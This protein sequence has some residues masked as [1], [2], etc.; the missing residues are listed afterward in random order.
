MTNDVAFLFMCFYAICKVFK[1]F[2]HFKNGLFL[3]TYMISLYTW[4]GI[5]YQLS[6]F[7][8]FGQSV[9]L[10]FH[11]LY[12]DFCR[13]EIFVLFVHCLKHICLNQSHKDP[14][15]FFP[16]VSQFILHLD[17]WPISSWFLW[18]VWEKCSGSFFCIWVSNSSSTICWKNI[19]SPLN[20]FDTFVSNKL[21]I[22]VCIYFWVLYSVQ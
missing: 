2:A 4:I 9:A 18:K 14:L 6:V 11:F 20:Y 1:W 16:E 5:L 12:C 17:L 21:T 15:L 13:T 7:H 10:S 22:N 19:L 8:F 3:I